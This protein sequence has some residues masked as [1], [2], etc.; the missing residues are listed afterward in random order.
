MKKEKEMLE[1]AYGTLD[2]LKSRREEA[3]YRLHLLYLELDDLLQSIK[4][5]EMVE[6]Q[7]SAQYTML[8]AREGIKASNLLETFVLRSRLDGAIN[9]VETYKTRYRVTMRDKDD[10]IG[11]IHDLNKD[12]EK[13]ESWIEATEQ[14]FKPVH[15][16]SL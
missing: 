10:M 16:K 4:Y 6:Q 7:V 1:N 12:I 2:E 5:S 3:E 13:L 8:L 9:D 15:T 14:F 11:T